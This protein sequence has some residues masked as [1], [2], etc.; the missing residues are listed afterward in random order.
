MTAR[1]PSSSLVHDSQPRWIL[2]LS[3]LRLLWRLTHRPPADVAMP[4]WQAA[5]AHATSGRVA[6]INAALLGRVSELVPLY[7]DLLRLLDQAGAQWVQI[8]EPVL[9]CA[10]SRLP[11]SRPL[12]PPMLP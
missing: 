7:A 8:D 12:E 3:A 2:A 1:V 10:T 11:R 5:V 9:V 6:A 4:G